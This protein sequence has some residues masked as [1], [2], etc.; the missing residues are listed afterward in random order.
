MLP[1]RGLP[2]SIPASALRNTWSTRTQPIRPLQVPI[3][4]F[5]Q[6]QSRSTRL[7]SVRNISC[8]PTSLFGSRTIVAATASSVFAQRSGASRNLSLWPF[9][10]KK[11]SPVETEPASTPE[12]LYTEPPAPVE[13]YERFPE[14]PLASTTSTSAPTDHTQS[15][16][17]DLDLTSVLDIPEQ[18]GY[19]KNLGLDFGWGPT[20]CCEWIL[21]HLYIYTGMPWWAAIAAVA[22]VWRLI[23]FWPTLTASK[24]S[25]LIQQLER[26]P[27]YAKAKEEFNEAAWKTRD[28]MAQMRASEKMMRLKK[29][30]GASTFRMLA[31]FWTVPFSFGMFRLLRGMAALPV[32]SLETGGLAWFTDLTVHDPY[33]ILP[34][35]SI[36]LTAVMFKQTRAASLSKDP[37]T[38][39]ITKLMMYGLPPVVFLGTAWL[40]AGVQWFFL[41]LTTGSIVQT[42]ATLNPTIRRLAGLPPLPMPNQGGGLIQTA[43]VATPTWQA[44]TSFAQRSA[45]E[46]TQGITESAKGLLGV[47]KQKEEWKKAQAYEERRAAEEK[48]KAYRRM[49]EL[50]R[51]QA[52]KGGL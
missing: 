23:M 30:T 27:A 21:E 3:R 45:S 1:S 25:A 18:I 22:A 38:E 43:A 34:I 20:S 9:S 26:N 5:S 24:H 15:A 52:E 35:T 13:N 14:E 32:P 44:P 39:G 16:F 29:E 41:M 7:N 12:P 48:E 49:E 19:L 11:Q 42:S 28:R 40:P 51:K 8:A 50:R 4:Y 17:S 10:S 2:R 33:Y 6:V 37:K 31:T 36:A 46:A 47:D